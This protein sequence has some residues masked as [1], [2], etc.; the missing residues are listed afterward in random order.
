MKILL[1]V[2]LILLAIF[3]GWQTVFNLIKYLQAKRQLKK[4]GG[5]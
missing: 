3:T 4:H 2:A 5:I 1:F